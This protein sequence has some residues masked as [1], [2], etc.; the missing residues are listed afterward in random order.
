[1]MPGWA[2]ICARPWPS[3]AGVDEALI[4]RGCVHGSMGQ[5]LATLNLAEPAA[6]LDR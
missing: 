2:P 1:M 4:A 5:L 6:L 3:V